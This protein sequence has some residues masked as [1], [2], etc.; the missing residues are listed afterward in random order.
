MRSPAP[1]RGSPLPLSLIACLP[2]RPPARP[3]PARAPPLARS[4]AR[5]SHTSAAPSARRA[6]ARLPLP[7]LSAPIILGR[8]RL[9][10]MPLSDWLSGR[11]TAVRPRRCAAGWPLSCGGNQC[12]RSAERSGRSAARSSSIAPHPPH[13]RCSHRMQRDIS[14]KVQP[15]CRRTSDIRGQQHNTGDVA[16]GA[17]LVQPVWLPPWEH[18]ARTVRPVCVQG[19]VWGCEGTKAAFHAVLPAIVPLQQHRAVLTG[20]LQDGSECSAQL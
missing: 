7:A 13:Y 5:R 17:A 14:T 8:P 20:A 12:G 2:A 10:S 11:A 9:A 15:L 19:C 4:P 1:D 3:G 16:L 18:R 6:A